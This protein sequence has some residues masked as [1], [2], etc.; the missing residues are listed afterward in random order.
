MANRRHLTSL[1]AIMAAFCRLP[2]DDGRVA[3]TQPT[4]TNHDGSFAVTFERHHR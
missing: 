1:K 4:E 2:Q 3:V